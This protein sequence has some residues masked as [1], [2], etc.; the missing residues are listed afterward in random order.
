MAAVHRNSRR[1][2]VLVLTGKKK[3]EKSHGKRRCTNTIVSR[4]RD[5]VII[6]IAY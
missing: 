4:S 5:E 2:Q 6:M 1:E 3:F